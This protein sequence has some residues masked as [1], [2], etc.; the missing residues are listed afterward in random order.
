MF[1]RKKNITLKWT[2]E[3][4]VEIGVITKEEMLLLKKDRAIKEW[5]NET[6]QKEKPKRKLKI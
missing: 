5:E 2:L 3:S 4:L 1:W 6:K